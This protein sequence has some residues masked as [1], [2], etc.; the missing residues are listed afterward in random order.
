MKLIRERKLIWTRRSE[1]VIIISKKWQELPRL[2]CAK[3]RGNLLTFHE[4]LSLRLIAHANTGRGVYELAVSQIMR[5]GNL[6]I[7]I[8]HGCE[9]S[10]R[11]RIRGPSTTFNI[12]PLYRGRHFSSAPKDPPIIFHNSREKL[13]FHLFFSFSREQVGLG[14]LEHC[15]I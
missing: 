7:C 9:N 12:I 1:R 8:S 3:T 14:F 4:R 11:T 2:I 10:V 13:S 6:S 15:C 5:C